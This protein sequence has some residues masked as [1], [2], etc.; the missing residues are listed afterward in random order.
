MCHNITVKPLF[1]IG[2]ILLN[3]PACSTLNY[4]SHSIS[5]HME[6]MSKRV[7]ISSLM[8][9]PEIS[10]RQSR[11]FNSILEIRQFATDHLLLPDNESYTTYVD[12]QRDFVV[13]NVFATPEFSLTPVNSC[14]LFVGCLQYRGFFAKQD[15][16]DHA[17]ELRGEGNDVFVGGVT[18]YSTLGWFND[19]VLSSMLSYGE[20]RLA[21]V[22]FHELAHQLIFIRDD[23]AFNE[24]FATAV[25]N[26]GVERWLRAGQRQT[27]LQ[28]LAQDKRWEKEFINLILETK[29]RLESLYASTASEEIMRTRKVHIFDQLRAEYQSL[30]SSW[31]D[32]PDYDEWM[33]HDLNNAKLASVVTYHDLADSFTR[34]LANCDD[35]L[36]VFYQR[37]RQLGKLPMPQRHQCL[38]TRNNSP[39]CYGAL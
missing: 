1:F 15:A 30:K 18:A 26:M 35:D 21:E 32:P 11:I 22:I 23:S 37:V 13:W 27:D 17:Q 2:L 9:T 20:F 38:T 7:S 29:I 4:Y 24:A 3:L 36:A 34:L 16:L 8:Q 19:P 39:E 31:S 25:A 10:D 14:F 33:E 5:G 12:L 6:V 28:K